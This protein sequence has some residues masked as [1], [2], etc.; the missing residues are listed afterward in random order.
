[1][2]VIK[3]LTEMAISFEKPTTGQGVPGNT[4]VKS[5]P[6]SNIPAT[7]W[8]AGSIDIEGE[9]SVKDAVV[10]YSY[11]VDEC[12]DPQSNPNCPGYVKPMPVLPVIEVYDALKTMLLLRR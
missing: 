3:T 1:M 10:I 12:F 4:I 9:G 8:G 11:R 7:Q 5:F 6:L 2:S